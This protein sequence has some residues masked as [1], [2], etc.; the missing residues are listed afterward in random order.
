MKSWLTGLLL[1]LLFHLSACNNESAEKQEPGAILSAEPYSG[2]TDSIKNDSKN[3]ALYQ[4]RAELLFQNGELELAHKDVLKVWEL[5]PTESHAEQL[6]NILFMTGKNKAAVDLLKVLIK[7]Y[8][9]NEQFQRRMS[10]ALVNSGEINQAIQSFDR[11]I[12]EDSANFEA[13][14]EKG[15][16]YLEEK[17]TAS[18]LR[19]LENSY[20]LQPLQLTAL[21]LANIYAETKNDRALVL[22]DRIIARDSTGEMADPFFIKGIYFVNTG[23]SAKALDLF[24]T[25]IRMNWKFQEAYIEKGIIYFES[26]NLDEAL[27]Q[28]KLAATVTNTYPEA[29]YWQGRC[30]EELGMK[31]EALANYGRAYSLDRTFQE[32]VEAAKRVEKNKQ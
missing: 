31:D 8:P 7:E 6:V 24:N 2:I 28:F 16:L 10:E 27:Q 32:A 21:T 5:D 26:K 12:E 9:E 15:L 29:Y 20:R 11:M 30:Y 4:R 3:P 1:G 13:W 17:D 22:A 23:N 14:F 25:C 19:D 18:A